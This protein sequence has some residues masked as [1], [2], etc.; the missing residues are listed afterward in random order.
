MKINEILIESQLQEGPMLDKFGKAVGGVASGVAKGVGAVAGGIAGMGSAFKKGFSAGKTTVAGDEAP[1]KPSMVGDLAKGLGK[2]AYKGATGYDLPGQDK[3]SLKKKAAQGG[4]APAATTAPAATGAAPAA[5]TA[6][7]AT[8]TAP[9]AKPTAP[10]AKPAAPG[11]AAAP[12]AAPNPKADTAYAQAQKAIAGLAPKQKSQLVKMLQSDPAVT[13][14]AK[15]PAA[16]APASKMA[17]TPVSK[18]N[19]AKPGNP[20]QAEIDADRAKIMGQPDKVD[21]GPGAGA[22]GAMAG[23]LAK[24][25]AAEPNTMANAPVSKTNKAKPGNPNAAPEPGMTADGEPY[26]DPATGKGSKY[27]GITGEMTPT[28]KAEQDKKAAEKQTKAAPAQQDAAPAPATPT[29]GQAATQAA[30]AGGNPEQAALDAMKAKNPKLAGM[31]A[32]AG[33]DDQGN[34]VEPVKK[35]GG[36]KKPAAPSQA[37]MD[38]DRERNMGPTSDSIIRTR[39]MMA[40][41]FSLFRKR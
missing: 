30:G 21:A 41:G 10:A 35:K 34:D 39:P 37:T 36:K 33:M 40:E 4:A 1:A 29:T 38:A 23:Q 27:D 32:Q 6:P 17:N 24:G 12:A 19:T 9:A 5:T 2:D 22:M 7:A 15:A 16:K 8:G 25:G 31:M 28:W 3:A 20:N 13:A 26:W 14:A 18:T 11:A